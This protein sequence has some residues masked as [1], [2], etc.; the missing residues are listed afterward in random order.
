MN[1]DYLNCFALAYSS[2][3]NGVIIIIVESTLP[4]HHIFRRRSGYYAFYFYFSM[5]VFI[6]P[7]FEFPISIFRE[8]VLLDFVRFLR[9]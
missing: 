6:F 3:F 1:L 9:F 8:D 5:F 4:S 2:V 7:R